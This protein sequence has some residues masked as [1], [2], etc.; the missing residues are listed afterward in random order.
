MVKNKE[1][2]FDKAFKDKENRLNKLNNNVKKIKDYIKENNN[3]IIDMKNKL[4][5]TE[6]NAIIFC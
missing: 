4:D 5:Y 2:E 6:N 1:D 3:K